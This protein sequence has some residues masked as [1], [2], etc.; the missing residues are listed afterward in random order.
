MSLRAS[1]T[2]S[3]GQRCHRAKIKVRLASQ[4]SESNEDLLAGYLGGSVY[5]R[6]TTKA[7]ATIHVPG[8][9]CHSVEKYGNM[10]LYAS[11]LYNEVFFSI[12]FVFL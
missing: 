1:V 8:R 10:H 3:S 11:F 4:R 7:G 9:G 12:F 6:G 5:P 2:T